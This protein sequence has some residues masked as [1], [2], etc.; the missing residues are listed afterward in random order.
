M[1][2]VSKNKITEGHFLNSAN[3]RKNVKI[4]KAPAQG[5]I[6]IKFYEE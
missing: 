1:V 5:L 3:P 6:L 4:F 2:A